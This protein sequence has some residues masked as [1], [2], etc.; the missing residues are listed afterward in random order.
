MIKK[1]D[2]LIR[3]VAGRE[4][5]LDAEDF[6]NRKILNSTL[7][8][9]ETGRVNVRN[10]KTRKITSLARVILNPPKGQV[11]DHK[12]RNP[13]DNRKCN[14]RIVTNRQNMLNRILEN[15]TGFIGVSIKRTKT[16]NN[17]PVYYARY[18]NGSKMVSFRSPLTRNGLILA[19]MA[20]DK[21]IILNSDEEYA[22]LNFPIFKKEPFKSILLKSDLQA[23]KRI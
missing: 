15:S 19:A 3:K 13:L 1:H 17:E 22:P 12:N 16:K 9:T 14:L 2:Y 7:L 11:V 4:V 21:F 18:S 20:R 5:K 6:Y 8:I 10:R 23:M